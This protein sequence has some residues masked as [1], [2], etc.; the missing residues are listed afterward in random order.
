MADMASTSAAPVPSIARDELAAALS[1]GQILLL[2]VLSPESYAANH[3]DG[4]LN[5]PV[6]DIPSR[7]TQV[8]PDLDAPIVVYCGGPT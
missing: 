3:I 2:D 4:A 7:A 6:A 5:L 8:A 1:R